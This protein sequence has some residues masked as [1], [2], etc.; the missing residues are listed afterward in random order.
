M[1]GLH[2]HMSG[3][4]RDCD[5]TY[6]QGH[7]YEMTTQ[8]K[9]DQFGDLQFKDRVITNIITLHG[10]GTLTV[11]PAGASWS[12]QTD[13][14]YRAVDILWCEDDCPNERSWQRDHRAEAMGY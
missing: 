3:S 1:T 13:E 14:G 4:S 8:E 9:A 12:E 2:A 11:T 5:G 6:S 7:V 10:Y